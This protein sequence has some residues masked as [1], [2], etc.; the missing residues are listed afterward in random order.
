MG[1]HLGCFKLLTV[2]NDATMNISVQI[3]VRVSASVLLGIY[4]EVE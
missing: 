3:S 2:G 4:P 1:V